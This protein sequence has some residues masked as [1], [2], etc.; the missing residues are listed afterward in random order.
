LSVVF[1][2]GIVHFAD[3]V[4]IYRAQPDF[5]KKFLKTVP[6]VF[7]ETHFIS[8]EPRK[9]IVMA[10]RKGNDWYVAGINGEK[11]LKEFSVELPFITSGEFELSLIADGET[12][13]T[14]NNETKAFKAGDTIPVKMLECG[15]FVAVL[16][17]K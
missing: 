8:G 5:I 11:S 13:R 6:V 1:N 2:C 10:S 15:G 16:K 12:A 7:D 3:N 17:A 14:F 9:S 4:K